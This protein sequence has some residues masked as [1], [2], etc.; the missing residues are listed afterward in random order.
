MERLGNVINQAISEGRWKP[1]K[2]SR[3]GLPLSHMFFADDLLLFIE[4]SK[5]QINVIMDCMNTFCAASGK[6]ISLLKSSIAFS[7][8]VDEAMTQKISCVSGI[9]IKS[10]LEK[11]LRVPFIMGRTNMGLFQHLLY[12]IDDKLDGWKTK[13][14][15]LASIIVIAKPTITTT[16]IYFM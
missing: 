13:Q 4:A 1:I 9:P 12:R 16:P 14:L 3:S 5:D 6:K 10:H 11:Y 7:S 2:L 8:G 15:T